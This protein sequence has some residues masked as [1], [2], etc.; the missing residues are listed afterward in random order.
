[1]L[2]NIRGYQFEV[3]NRVGVADPFAGVS[4]PLVARQQ[5]CLFE[6]PNRFRD[7]AQIGDSGQ[8]GE[9]FERRPRLAGRAD[10]L[11]MAI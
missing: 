10:M 9:P 6:P 5:G 4:P 8:L 2:L 1:M 7:V 3:P 11:K